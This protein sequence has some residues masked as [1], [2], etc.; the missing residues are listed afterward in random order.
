MWGHV[1]G[2]PEISGRRRQTLPP[3]G[4]GLPWE[5]HLVAQRGGEREVRQVGHGQVG[6]VHRLAEG[7]R[8][9]TGKRRDGVIWSHNIKFI[10]HVLPTSYLWFVDK[11]F[12]FDPLYNIFN[13]WC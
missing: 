8:L 12:S 1:P 13:I 9:A 7:P 2:L 6:R 5:V 11:M 10:Q 3:V 4:A